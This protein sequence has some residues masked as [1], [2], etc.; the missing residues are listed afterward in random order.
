MPSVP[1]YLF[2]VVLAY[3]LGSFPTGYL[4][5]RAFTGDDV[6]R[7]GSGRTGG[8]NVLRSAGA[9]PA[10]LTVLG[11]GLKGIAAVLVAR[12]LAGTPP[13]LAL[14]GVAAVLGHNHSVFLSWRGGAGTITAIG[15]ALAI[16]PPVAGGA[17][18]LGLI[19]LLLWRYA[20]LGSI[21]IAL[22]LPVLFAAGAHWLGMPWVYVAYAGAAGTISLLSLRPNIRRLLAGQERRLGGTL[23]LLVPR[24]REHVAV[25]EAVHPPRRRS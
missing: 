24:R 20:S 17:S 11:D 4:L 1:S 25:T 18:A 23:R 21:T 16:S 3:L 14:A 9:L 15:V 8:T 13:A 19:V 7:V 2:A 6:R 5:V 12:A 22:S 10:I